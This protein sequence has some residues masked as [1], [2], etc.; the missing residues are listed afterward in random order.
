MPTRCKDISTSPDRAIYVHV[1]F[2]RQRCHYC[3]FYSQTHLTG[4]LPMRFVRAIAQRLE[5]MRDT[6]TLPATSIFIGGGTPTALPENAL[7][8]LLDTLSAVGNADTE[9]TIEA[10]PST[11]DDTIASLLAQ[12]GVNRVSIGAQSFIPEELSLLGRTHSPHRIARAVTRVRNAGISNIS[13]DLIFGI[14]GQTPDT[15]ARSLD[16]ALALRP[17]HV[18]CY[19]LSIPEGTKLAQMQNAGMMTPMDDDAQ[20][21]LYDQAVGTLEQAGLVRY[22]ISNFAR[23][24]RQCRHNRVYWQ[25]EPYLGLGP[26]AASYREGVRITN[27]SDIHAWLDAVERDESPP[28]DCETLTGRDAM[29]ETAMLGL[30]LVE[31]VDRAGFEARFGVDLVEAFPKTLTRYASLDAVEITDTH[32]R[33]TPL[34]LFTAN[35]ILADLLDEQSPGTPSPYDP[36]RHPDVASET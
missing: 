7:D 18:S 11:L 13:L 4:D 36:K 27:T 15:W 17:D 20:R 23:D 10:N 9:F 14:P 6:L 5:V 1:P 3:D 29:A 19:A 8:E 22:E 33:I 32:V 30:R 25:N 16:A 24:G 31:G 12:R 28:E 2:C 21:D 35:A 34:A 26:A